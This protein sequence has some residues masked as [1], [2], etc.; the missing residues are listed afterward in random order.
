MF[1]L[2]L[3]NNSLDLEH[4]S[5]NMGAHLACTGGGT[6]QLQLQLQAPAAPCTGGCHSVSAAAA[7]IDKQD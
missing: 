7:A 4:L 5:V 6:L 2:L 1:S 3:N